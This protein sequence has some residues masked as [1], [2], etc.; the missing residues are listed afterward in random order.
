VA[1]FAASPLSGQ[2]P[3]A[4]SFTDLSSNGPTSWLWSFGDGAT[5]TEQS[6]THTYAAPGLY[7]VSLTATNAAGSDTELRSAYVGVAP[8]AS[9]LAF[10][11]IADAKVAAAKPDRNY[12]AAPNLSVKITAWRSYLR[13]DVAGLG[14]P[15]L[16]ATLRL[17]VGEGSSDGGALYETSDAWSEETITWNTAPPLLGAAIASLGPVAIGTWVEVDVTA[18]VVADGSYAFGLDGTSTNLAQ[19]GSRESANAPQLVIE[20]AR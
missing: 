15:V 9:M 16:R 12:G 19:Y 3:L 13:F 6:P 17:F 7:D 2:A 5:S 11:P 20:V 4:V 1:D 14:G 18:V 10:A 8:G